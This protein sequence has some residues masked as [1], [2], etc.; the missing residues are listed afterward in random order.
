MAWRWSGDKPLSEPMMVRLPTHI[1]VTRPQW[2]NA[3]RTG[4]FKKQKGFCLMSLTTN[5]IFRMKPVQYNE[6]LVSTM[7]IDGLVLL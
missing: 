2:V 1:C 5:I 6:Y 3:E 4:S 7:G